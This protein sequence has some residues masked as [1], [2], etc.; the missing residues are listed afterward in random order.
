[1]KGFNGFKVKENNNRQ[2]SNSQL[3]SYKQNHGPASLNL[4][5]I[6]NFN[7]PQ[8]EKEENLLR[9]HPALD[10]SERQVL[11]WLNDKELNEFENY[12][13][14]NDI[15]GE[16]LL[17]IN[18]EYL[19]MMGIIKVGSRVRI[20][21]AINLLK[22]E[23]LIKLKDM[24]N[25]K[26]IYSAP[27]YQTNNK[28]QPKLS[29]IGTFNA[30]LRRSRSN[31]NNDKENTN[32]LNSLYSI[33]SD[34]SPPISP[35]IQPSL[36]IF[37]SD[38]KTKT[39]ILRDVKDR[40]KIWQDI[41][42]SFGVEEGT[43]KYAIF[44]VSGE[45]TRCLNS[46]ELY[47]I[48]QDNSRSLR[49]KLIL[50]KRHLNKHHISS[51]N[52]TPNNNNRKEI[53][54]S[55]TSSKAVTKQNKLTK[56]FGTRPP[57]ELISSNLMQ[58]FPDHKT[59]GVTEALYNLQNSRPRPVKNNINN[60]SN[61]MINNNNNA[62]MIYSRRT[63]LETLNEVTVSGI[64]EANEGIENKE[65]KCDWVKGPC[66]GSGS[67]GDVY[68]GLNPINGELMAVKQVLLPDIYNTSSSVKLS[69]QR[70]DALQ[71]EI[72]LLKGFNH[73]NIVRYLGSEVKDKHLNILLEY[74]PG[75]SVSGQLNDYG[76]FKE[77]LIQ[78]YVKQILVGLSFLH[79]QN[80]VHR[81]IKGG[82]ILVDN[83]GIVKITDFGVSKKLQEEVLSSLTNQRTSLQ[84]SIYWMAP[85]VIKQTHYTI[86][87]DIWA[88][89]CLVIEML[90]GKHPYPHFNQMQAIFKIGCD[91]A[92]DI[93][94]H[95]S[96][97]VKSFLQKTFIIDHEQRP[98]AIELLS[99][100]FVMGQIKD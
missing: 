89:G 11:Q 39:V 94:E 2:P 14:K 29:P 53:Q 21:S 35:E 65:F 22:R 13:I 36:R 87:A 64:G 47:E 26:Q 90:T 12:F 18:N 78:V 69:Q 84:G 79:S 48:C 77:T 16:V 86:K 23:Y 99:H 95:S 54:N 9:K 40:E 67:F 59:E 73:P 75:G 41:L 44:L 88:L 85:E 37:G 81:D 68:L 33:Y 3:Q 24:A 32:S 70:L 15:N 56:I 20:L 74:V 8:L 80:I 49:E 55:P 10:W 92:P 17:E 72:E 97:L 34:P 38:G 76:P 51:N 45:A 66:I 58:F 63:K 50:R 1:M 42:K 57:S 19:K 27:L 7:L 61:S 25:Y 82:N 30:L 43:E 91:V 4:S 52:L 83:K 100:P 5:T 28:T 71:R 62:S 93:P 31:I 6:S 60:I 96:N 46:Q 98:T